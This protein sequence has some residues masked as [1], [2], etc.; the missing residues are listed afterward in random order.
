MLLLT[1]VALRAETVRLHY[2]VSQLE[3]RADACREHLRAAELELARL[4]NPM[5]IRQ[6]VRE[7]VQQFDAAGEPA[8]ETNPGSQR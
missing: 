5:L 1:V 4:R 8:D 3:H 2:E 6:R 7:A